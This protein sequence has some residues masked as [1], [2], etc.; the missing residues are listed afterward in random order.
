MNKFIIILA[1]SLFLFSCKQTPKFAY[2][3][4]DQQVTVNEY[5]GQKIEDPYRNL[6]NLK[7][8]TVISW[9]KAQNNLSDSVLEKI[10][11]RN[12][13]VEKQKQFDQENA[14]SV[15][16]LR[17][18]YNGQF[19][20]LKQTAE[21]DSPKLYY[22]K[23][24]Q[25]P[26]TLL[27]DSNSIKAINLDGNYFIDYIKPN[28][29]GEKIAIGLSKENDDMSK[30]IVIDVSSKEVISDVLSNFVPSIGGIQWL[31]N[32]TG[33][34]YVYHPN[35]NPQDPNYGLNTKSVVYNINKNPSVQREFFS[36]SNNPEVIL[37]PEDFPKVYVYQGYHK[38]IFGQVSGVSRFKDLYYK[39]SESIEST[40]TPWKKLYDK[41]DMV[42]QIA[43]NNDTIIFL[44][45][46]NASNFK[47][48]KTNIL[49]PD[50]K[51]PEIIIPESKETVITDIAVNDTGLYYVKLRNGVEAKL[52]HFNG[53]KEEEIKLPRPSG[54]VAIV[55]KG[56]KHPNLT[57]YSEGWLQEGTLYEYNT[58]N[59]EFVNHQ[60]IPTMNHP[61]FES[62]VVKE[63][64][65]ESHDGAMVPLSI[66][67]KKDIKMNGEN[68]TLFTG[69]GSYGEPGTPFFSSN[70]LTWVNEGGI[71]AI[72]HVRGG[73]EKG[74][75]WYRGGFKE[76]KPNTWKDIISC[77]EF[78]IKKG[79]TNSLKSSIMGSS[80][81]GIMAGR[82]VIERPDLYNALLLISPAMNMVRS[83]IQPNG[84]NSIKEF[85]TVKKENEFKAL[86]E[87]DSYHNIK[88]GVKYPATLVT[89]G[90]NDGSVVAWDS[91]KFVAQLQSCSTNDTAPIL[92][93]IDFDGG[94]SGM[95]LSMD[96]VYKLYADMFS[97][98]LW[99]TGHPDY[100]PKN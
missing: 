76:N 1:L 37:N 25:S 94:H 69:Y 18:T 33:L 88:Q 34:T 81:G 74:D 30:I 53:K 70:F 26:E 60:I 80:A 79:Y 28:W 84:P 57:V 66:I 96:G 43:L 58:D 19:F 10:P 51:N 15:W 55:S 36:Q 67:H 97:F 75:D 63:I 21:E 71:L 54:N 82:A 27:F 2:P 44:T 92:F 99:Q 38:Y 39:S 56:Y 7:D 31:P 73:G 72:A 90:Y 77:T 46:K 52:Y 6:E 9:L 83:E 98:A 59:H 42:K 29:K 3:Q 91:S 4:I 100:Q 64:E 89:A 48:C 24:L 78:M 14:F 65:V 86:L 16:S 5:H 62:L 95:N 47:I 22:K 17:E 68:P 93:S 35:I 11:N 49:K 20:F 61:E 85:G 8:S 23:S 87:M 40:N 32:D 45:A 50:F 41:S 13:I 12:K